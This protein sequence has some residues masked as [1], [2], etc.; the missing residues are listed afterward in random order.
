M[1][2][3]SLAGDLLGEGVV[4]NMMLSAAGTL[5][6]GAIPAG[7]QVLENSTLKGTL[8]VAGNAYASTLQ[9]VSESAEER[10]ED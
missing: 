7:S 5:A 3:N 1:I 8:S 4:E 2:D 10:I 6:A 9:E